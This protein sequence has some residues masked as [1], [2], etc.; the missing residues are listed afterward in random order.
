VEDNKADIFLIREAIE[1]T[2]LRADLHIVLDGEKAVRFF[3]Q[4]DYDDSLPCP[5]LVIIDINL[6]K[7]QGDE[8]L[9]SMRST[10]RCGKA[11]VLVVTSSD[12]A[13][14]RAAM[15]KHG[16]EGYFRKPSAYEDFMKL[17]EVVEKLIR[18][19]PEGSSSGRL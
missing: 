9:R 12:S 1:T 11:L 6:P 8:V 2:N 3:E 15:S 7:K 17:G 16:I 10:R 18:S 19:E 5:D 4:L 14:D 13:S